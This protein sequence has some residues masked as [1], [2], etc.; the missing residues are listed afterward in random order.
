MWYNWYYGKWYYY[1]NVRVPD[2]VLRLLRDHATGAVTAVLALGVA[3]FGVGWQIHTA[4]RQNTEQGEVP[5][6]VRLEVFDCEQRPLRVLVIGPYG[7]KETDD[8]GLALLPP[9]WA[10]K[11]ISVRSL[12]GYAEIARVVLNVGADRTMP[13]RIPCDEHVSQ[14][15]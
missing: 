11:T 5:T 15:K 9:D 7:E 3:A 6:P 10:G 8:R 4:R 14:I 2:N 1:F 12:D 13:L